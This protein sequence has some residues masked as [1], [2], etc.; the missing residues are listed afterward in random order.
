M[1]ILITDYQKKKQ[2]K[3]LAIYHDYNQ[4]MSSPNAMKVAVQEVLMKK[5]SIH[6]RSTIWAILKRV[7]RRIK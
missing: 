4:L 6:S 1:A 2:A 3:E 7:E 5:Y